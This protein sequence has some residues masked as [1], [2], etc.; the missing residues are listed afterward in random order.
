MRALKRSLYFILAAVLAALILVPAAYIHG[1]E[2]P[3][4]NNGLSETEKVEIDAKVSALKAS[5]KDSVTLEGKIVSK[6]EAAACCSQAADSDAIK[7]RNTYVIRDADAA[8]DGRHEIA[9][10]TEMDVRSSGT[11]EDTKVCGRVTAYSKTWYDQ[12]SFSGVSARKVTK[13][14]GRI[15][16]N[17]QNVTIRKLR[18]QYRGYGSWFTAA[19]VNH[20]TG[21]Y[22]RDHDFT[23]G[24]PMTMKTWSPGYDRYYSRAGQGILQTRFYVT[25]GGPSA[26]QQATYHISLQL[27]SLS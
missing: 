21:N 6:I 23:V 11:K 3:D 8:S 1:A 20:I 15:T 4:Q 27:C 12:R 5:G 17:S 13:T 25:Y 26:D 14:G 16:V 7:I 24:N 9:T 22:T 18:S 19:G 10:L 2:G